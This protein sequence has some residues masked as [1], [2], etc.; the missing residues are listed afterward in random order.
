MARARAA[1]GNLPPT[2]KQR[3]FAEDYARHG[4]GAQAARHAGYTGT[5][6][7][8]AVTA[9]TLLRRPKVRALVATA[10]EARGLAQDPQKVVAGVAALAAPG[11]GERTQ[12]KLKAL[13]LLGK[14]HAIWTDVHAVRDLPRDPAKL[15]DIVETELLRVLG[16]DALL[17]L[18]DRVRSERRALTAPAPGAVTID[19]LPAVAVGAPEV[20]PAVSLDKPPSPKPPRVTPAKR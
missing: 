8:L 18:A 12:D 3:L 5:S 11:A 20:P 1:R 16:P 17:Q 15:R 4:I 2:V 19:V 6:Q 9:S 10:L 7:S 13:E 14:F